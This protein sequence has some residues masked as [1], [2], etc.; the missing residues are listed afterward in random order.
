[1]TTKVLLETL[2]RNIPET[3]RECFED[4][5]LISM[6]TS[7]YKHT[8]SSAIPSV[9]E[10]KTTVTSF[11]KRIRQ[12][13]HLREL[14]YAP[15]RSEE[16]LNQRKNLLTASDLASALNK[17]KFSSR[18]ALLKKKVE[19]RQ[20][21]PST[22]PLPNTTGSNGGGFKNQAMSWGTMFEPMISRIY[23][24]INQDITLYEFGLVQH[25]TLSCFGA[26]PD[27][28]TELGKMVEI[29]CPWRRE[30]QSG[31]VPEH[32]MLQIQGQ[33]AVC[34]LDE[35]DYIEVVMEDIPDEETYLR[36]VDAGE[37]HGH[38]VIIEIQTSQDQNTG[39]QRYEYSPAKLTPRKAY[40][41][42]K[43]C[44]QRW[45]EKDPNVN[46]MRIRPWKMKAMNLVPV[47][48][49]AT[50]WESIVPQIQQ[51]WKEVEEKTLEIPTSDTKIEAMAS[52]S[53]QRKTKKFMYRD[54]PDPMMD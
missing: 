16:W 44:V 1:M 20:P 28:I 37:T 2:W 22:P 54:D 24:E 11:I 15:Q 50:L 38:G 45:I 31:E 18:S 30:I 42:A 13:Q 32:Y 52:P 19:A 25:P 48:F 12:V 4:S 21:P 23:S 6:L 17:G 51:F 9:D 3:A 36:L 49:D 29:K 39:D 10:I 5:H 43:K 41:W 35:C 8:P 14:V 26:S 34:G 7:I 33:L 47:T 40:R 53:R 27:G 46:I